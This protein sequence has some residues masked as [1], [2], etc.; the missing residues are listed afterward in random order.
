[1][2]FGKMKGVLD[3]VCC[4]KMKNRTKAAMRFIRRN[5]DALRKEPLAKKLLFN[6]DKAFFERN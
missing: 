1:M 2:H 6:N 5:E 4:L 3:K